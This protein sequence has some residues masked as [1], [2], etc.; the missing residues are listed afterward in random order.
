MALSKR[1]KRKKKTASQQKNIRTKQHLKNRIE[2]EKR[3]SVQNSLRELTK[4]QFDAFCYC[5][6][7]LL[8][9][10][11]EEVAWFEAYNRKLLIVLIRDVTDNDF[12]YVILGRDTRKMF[13]CIE[14]SN[15]FHP[16]PEQAF[17]HLK[18][19]VYKLR[20]SVQEIYPQD[21][22]KKAP[23]EILIPAVKEDKF[24]PYFKYLI[25]EPR[26]EA[27]RNVIKEIVY[28]YVDPDG[29]YIKEFQTHG[30]DARLW[31]LYLY[32]YFHNAG[33][34]LDRKTPAPDYHVRPLVGGRYVASLVML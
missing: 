16:T 6:Q 26:F 28:S 25:S 3:R 4:R 31:E 1:Q 21:D 32:I 9:F 24:H 12:G 23:N 30:F 8:R 29:N 20:N 27:A 10:T 13:R 34:G 14:V 33:F 18:N 5:R 19:R 17:H 11:A 7:P 15:N 22:E 2:N